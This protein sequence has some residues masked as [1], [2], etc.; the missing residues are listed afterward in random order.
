MF[1][2]SFQIELE[3]SLTYPSARIICEAVESYAAGSKERL[4]F[5]SREM[6]VSFYL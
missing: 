4:T 1:R 5:V 2:K 3:D 6:P